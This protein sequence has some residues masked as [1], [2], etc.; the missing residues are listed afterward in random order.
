M[1]TGVYQRVLLSMRIAEFPYRLR[2]KVKGQLL[3]FQRVCGS[4][5]P[6]LAAQ[7]LVFLGVSTHTSHAWP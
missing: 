3:P 6:G 7:G 4:C 2:F 1:T 5:M